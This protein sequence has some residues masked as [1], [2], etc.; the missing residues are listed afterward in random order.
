MEG[1]GEALQKPENVG[2]PK[3]DVLDLLLLNGG[4]DLIAIHVDSRQAT[5]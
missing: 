4:E 3:V 5:S 2:K 1:Y